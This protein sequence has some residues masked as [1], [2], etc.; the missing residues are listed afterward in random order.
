MSLAPGSDWWNAGG[1]QAAQGGGAMDWLKGLG[2][3]AYSW[4]GNNPMEAL[5]LGAGAVGTGMGILDQYKAN[6]ALRQRQ[7]LAESF[8]RMGPT[9]FNPNW[10]PEQL[11]ARYFRPASHFMADRGITS[12]GAFNQGLADAALKAEMDRNQ[13][14]N[15]IY[16][17]RLSALG[18][19]GPVPA[20]GNTGA[21]GG[22]LQNIMLQRA[23][24]GTPMGVGRTQ[25]PQQPP[26][27][28]WAPPN[29]SDT[30]FQRWLQQNPSGPY[31]QDFRMQ[32]DVFG[33]A[34]ADGGAGSGDGRW[35]GGPFSLG[36][37]NAQ[38]GGVPG[39]YPDDAIDGS[40]GGYF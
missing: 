17:S 24:A 21:F 5:S 25:V 36:G 4:A 31:W 29:D 19:G 13:I 37:T 11:Q 22:A 20:S 18:A 32:G 10:S 39:F 9:A 15:Q 27:A 34:G 2:S 26:G 6:Q 28:T 3:N 14:G 8:S 7:K 35:G 30:D 23:L 1:G 38:G 33:R 12:G 16:Q 40:G